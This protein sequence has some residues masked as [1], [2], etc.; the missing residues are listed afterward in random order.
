MH[1]AHLYRPRIVTAVLTIVALAATASP[2]LAQRDPAIA[3]MQRAAKDLIAASRT[4]SPGAFISVMQ[5]HGDVPYIGLYSLGTYKPRLDAA[6]R[7]A[8]LTGMVRFIARYSA[9]EAPKYPVSHI[10]FPTPARR[11]RAGVLVDSKLHLRDGTVYEVTWL[12]AKYGTTY[13][14]RDAQVLNFWAVPFLQ[15]LFVNYI[16]DNGGNV[17]ALVVVLN[18]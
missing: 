1:V 18:R 3:F 14:V 13:R 12:L 15:R 8:Y 17:K 7:A 10:E 5:R 2:G 6:D 16:E 11:V 9:T 4:H